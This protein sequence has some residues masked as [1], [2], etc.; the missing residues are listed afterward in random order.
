M[1]SVAPHPFE[2][3]GALSFASM[4]PHTR[5]GSHRGRKGPR[6]IKCLLS[7]AGFTECQ[8]FFRVSLSGRK[9]ASPSVGPGHIFRDVA[10]LQP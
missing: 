10:L 3:A 9:V 4:K 1:M 8:D 2:N 7:R 6:G 5:A